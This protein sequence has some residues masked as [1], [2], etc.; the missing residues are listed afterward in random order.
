[1]RDLASFGRLIMFI[2]KVF[3]RFADSS[4]GESRTA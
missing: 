1:M 2:I 4:S 3:D